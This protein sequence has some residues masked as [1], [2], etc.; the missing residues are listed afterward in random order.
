MVPPILAAE[1]GHR[2]WW[3]GAIEFRQERTTAPHSE[4]MMSEGKRMRYNRP[5]T[6]P[7]RAR[8][9]HGGNAIYPLPIG[10]A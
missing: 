9:G 3:L 4:H 6:L 5:M 8:N 1:S 7:N 10:K 2:A